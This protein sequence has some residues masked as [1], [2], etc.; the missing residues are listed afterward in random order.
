MSV[1]GVAEVLFAT[2][3]YDELAPLLERGLKIYAEMLGHEHP[4]TA[5]AIN[6][7]GALN[8][9]RGHYAE[10]RGSIVSRLP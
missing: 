8:S 5:D 7:M 2:G 4:E 10:A 3:E 9:R 1:V 6:D